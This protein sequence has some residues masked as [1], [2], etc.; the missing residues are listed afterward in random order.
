MS[1]KKTT[2]ART[3][4]NK[5]TQAIMVI[6]IKRKTEEKKAPKPFIGRLLMISI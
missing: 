4:Q 2:T 1:G 3:T 6:Y 5:Q